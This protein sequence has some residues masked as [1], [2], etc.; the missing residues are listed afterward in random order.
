MIRENHSLPHSRSLKPVNR[1]NTKVWT[2]RQGQMGYNS[3]MRG[4][5]IGEK[6]RWNAPEL[7]EVPA[8]LADYDFVTAQLLMQRGI[9][10][11]PSAEAFLH[12]ELKDLSDPSLMKDLDKAVE[13]IQHAITN[14]EWIV[15]YGDYDVDG[16][17]SATV[18][19]SALKS[20]GAKASVYLPERL[21]EG[22]GLNSEAVRQIKLDGADLLITVDNGTTSVD[23]IALAN[24]LGLQVIV[25]DH[26]QIPDKLPE[27]LALIN[28]KL[29]D[30]EY[31]FREMAAVGVT[32]SIVRKL[33]GDTEAQQYLDLVALG[34]IADIVPL[35]SDNRI[36]AVHGLKELNQTKRVGL[37]ALIE[38][39]G[40][41]GQELDV[42]HVGFQLGPRLNAAGRL[43]H[44]RLAFD[45]LNATDRE[46]AAK[47]ARELNDLNVRRQEMTDQMLKAAMER[48]REFIEQK[49]IVVGDTNWSIGVAGIVA[50]RLVEQYARPALVFE[51][52]PEVCK[53]SCRSVDGVHIVELLKKVESTIDHFGG[54][55]KAAGLSVKQEK[56]KE[57]KTELEKVALREISDEELRPMLNVAVWVDMSLATPQLL[58]IIQRFAPF[59]FGNSLPIVGVANAKLFAY[60]LFGPSS[61]HLRLTFMDEAGNQ[62]QV[63][64]WDGW[65]MTF[66]I[67]ANNVYDVAF[68][69]GVSTWQGRSFPQN[70]LAGIKA[71]S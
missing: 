70:K 56:F 29:S 18:L 27:A 62:L 66:D 57:F 16:V 30:S 2:G 17:T 35:L 43:D 44:A 10:D 34:T 28:P 14:K 48:E 45:L 64:A 31:P 63:V 32:Y 38:V 68:T 55:A 15:V 21:K 6:T 33:V 51:F 60:E 3:E 13:R 58:E 52:Q 69:M 9:T 59:G 61:R 50:S 67:K 25:I 23:D 36:L 22:Y 54:H 1:Q 65:E 46:A 4:I 71:S 19:T 37:Q 24:S 26:H 12:P 39:A 40:L 53:G 41:K 42:Y 5:L 20:L 7:T 8:G 49:V 47:L 11:R